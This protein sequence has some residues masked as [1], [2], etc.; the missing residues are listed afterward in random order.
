MEST[1]TRQGCSYL[2]AAPMVLASTAG[3]LQFR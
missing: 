3:E 1:A 2:R